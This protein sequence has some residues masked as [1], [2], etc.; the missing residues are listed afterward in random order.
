MPMKIKLLSLAT[1]LCFLWSSG[2]AKANDRVALLPNSG[3]L[4]A[5]FSQGTK[6]V[7]TAGTPV[8]LV[9]SVTLV[10]SVEIHARKNTTTANTG[11]IYLGFSSTGGSNYR[12]LLAGETFS[13]TAPAGKKLDLHLIYLDAATSADAVTYTAQN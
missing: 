10:E 8:R 5:T 3:T 1:F 13:I 4:A 9:A 6:A 12:V 11:A 7:A 2:I